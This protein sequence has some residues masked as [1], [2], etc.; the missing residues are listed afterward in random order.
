MRICVDELK[1]VPD[2]SMRTSL[3][4]NLGNIMDGRPKTMVFIT[5]LE[6]EALRAGS[7]A[8]KR[9]VELIPL[10]HTPQML[11]DLLEYKSMVENIAASTPTLIET[12]V[13]PRALVDRDADVKK[14][15]QLLSAC[16]AVSGVAIRSKL[17]FII[18]WSTYLYPTRGTALVQTNAK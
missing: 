6:P 3:I 17:V 16:S 12:T 9:K 10:A 15:N 14:K 4:T 1:L 13:C 18:P 11:L 8:S 5:A 2:A 7:N